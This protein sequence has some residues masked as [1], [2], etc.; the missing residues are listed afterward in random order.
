M[1]QKR[2]VHAGVQ[3][4]QLRVLEAADADFCL[5]LEG[6]DTLEADLEGG[7]NA[8]VFQAQGSG[9]LAW[10]RS[11]SGDGSQGSPGV[12]NEIPKLQDF[13]TV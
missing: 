7:G 5:E 8:E 12:Y 13:F 4:H 1:K 9:L 3:L 2:G 10:A 6:R 11:L